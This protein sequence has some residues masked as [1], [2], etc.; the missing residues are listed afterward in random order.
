[1]RQFLNRWTIALGA[2]GSVVGLFWVFVV[3]TAVNLYTNLTTGWNAAM[4]A[5]CPVIRLIFVAWWLVPIVNGL[6][7]LGLSSGIRFAARRRRMPP[8]SHN[9]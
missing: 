4:Y 3:G 7:Y 8:S 2:L 1:M 9:R 5:T 6:L